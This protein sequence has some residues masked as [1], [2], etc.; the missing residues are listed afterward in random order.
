MSPR[1]Q[2]KTAL[3]A[4]KLSPVE[5]AP[6]AV[7]EEVPGVVAPGQPAEVQ[8]KEPAEVAPVQPD[9][10]TVTLPVGRLTESQAAF[11]GMRSSNGVGLSYVQTHVDLQLR[12]PRYRAHRIALVRL[13]NAL[14]AVGA[15][16]ANGGRVQSNADVIR[17]MLEQY[18]VAAQDQIP[19]K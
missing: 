4:D 11:L 19:T 13:R 2:R 17:Y 18:E 8:H 7:A 10:C 3:P 15:R 14:D 12:G 9:D 16:L 1:K 6:D 5:E